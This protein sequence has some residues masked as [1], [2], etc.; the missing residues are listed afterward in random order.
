MVENCGEKEMS[1]ENMVIRSKVYGVVSLEKSKR[2]CESSKI[3]D[4][5]GCEFEGD[6]SELVEVVVRGR[7]VR[8]C[9]GCAEAWDDEIVRPGV[10]T[11]DEDCVLDA[12]QQCTVCGVSHTEICP[13][14]GGRGFHKDDCQEMRS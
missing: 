5:E 7:R 1:M 12:D 8:I 6:A 11:R 10:H 3:A 4:G 13:F 14:C 2:I 9:L